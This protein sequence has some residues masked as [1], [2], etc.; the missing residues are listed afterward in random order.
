MATFEYQALTEA[1]RLM[2]GTIEADSADEAGQSLARMQLTVNSI[3]KA[4]KPRPRTALG[5]GELLL[6]NQQLASLTASG[7]PLVRGLREIARDVQSRPMR[8]V[9]EGIAE[10][11][12]RGA[13]VEEAFDR[14]QQH[15]PPLYSEII[16]AGVRTG[17][18]SEMLTSLNRHL[19]IAAQTRRILFESLCYP[20]VV[21]AMSAVVLTLLF[22]VAVPEMGR[23]LAEMD[24]L[25]PWSTRLVI[26]MA[27]NLVPIWLVVGGIVC[28]AVVI[29]RVLICTPS[30]RMVW[31][32]FI[33]CIPVLGR[34]YRRGILARLAD[35]MAVLVASGNDLPACFRLAGGASASEMALADCRTVAAFVEKGG[36]ITD[37]ASHCAIIPPLMLHSMRFGAERNEL[38]DALYSM[39]EMYVLQARQGQ[40]GLQALL[41]PVLLIV[42]GSIVGGVLMTLFLPF[43]SMIENIG[44][45]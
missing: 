30:G 34:I 23:M 36:N 12:E 20:I 35:A 19:E 25:L 43:T 3:A 6:F 17:R 18:L 15:F 10:D 21:L 24:V 5:R 7:I 22:L 16:K 11:L 27:D 33:L 32:R 41:M 37:A 38:E 45:Y 39:A 28:A 1:G 40:G 29:P 2:K 8:R 9:I 14:H 31:E 4:P 44:G 26:V 13:K 42:V